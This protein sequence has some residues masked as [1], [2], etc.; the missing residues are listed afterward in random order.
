M[1]VKRTKQQQRYTNAQR[2]RLLLEFRSSAMNDNQYCL[3]NGIPPT[4][5]KR[6]RSKEE[7]IL[8]NKRHGRCPTMGGQGKKP[9]MPFQEE[10]LGYMRDRRDK[11][12]YLRAFHLMLW[13]K[14]NQRPWLEQYLLTKKNPA[15]GYECLSRLLRRFCASHRFSH[16][17]PCVNKVTQAVLDEVWIGY[18]VHFWA[19][20][21][22]YD[23]SRIFNA[24]ET[25]VYF[26]R[27]ATKQ[28]VGRSWEVVQSGEEFETF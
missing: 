17:V 3:S 6:W 27:H 18:A 24:D 2:K 15:N 7:L 26:V 5:W 9:L 16:R 12:K 23:R 25:G 4:T 19:K 1:P 11:E 20:Y 28:D 8:H 10:L 22:E 21:S 13:V 14:R